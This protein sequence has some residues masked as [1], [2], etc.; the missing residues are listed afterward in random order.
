MFYRMQL[1]VIIGRD[2]MGFTYESVKSLLSKFSEIE[3][4]RAALTKLKIILDVEPSQFNELGAAFLWRFARHQQSLKCEKE[5]RY[6]ERILP[7]LENRHFL[8]RLTGKT[9]KT[10][11]ESVPIHYESFRPLRIGAKEKGFKSVEDVYNDAI[12]TTLDKKNDF[13][14]EF[15]I[16]IL[17]VINNTFDH[18]ESENEAGIVC[19]KDNQMMTVCAV[20]M[21]QGIRKS[22]LTNPSLRDEY[23]RV[24][25]EKIIERASNFRTSCN[26]SSNRHPKYGSTANGGIG[27]YFLKEFIKL[28]KESQLIIVSGKGYYYVDGTGREKIKNLK[29]YGWPGT[30]VYF[31]T[32]VSQAAN[33]EYKNL[34]QKYLVESGALVEDLE[35]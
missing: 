7:L 17:E 27:L 2:S 23:L 25:E 35:G 24:P 5:I 33:P 20:D 19:V 32:N 4:N 8:D 16:H 31:R 30:L 26:P 18:S 6:S 12:K 14:R 11:S 29:E 13:Q 22:F 15:G 21:G 28:H 3:K 34:T 9:T 10:F 1:D